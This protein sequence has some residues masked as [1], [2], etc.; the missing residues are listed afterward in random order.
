MLM[1][2]LYV[3][4]VFEHVPQTSALK[5]L[6]HSALLVLS[7]LFCFI[8]PKER[9]SNHSRSLS[10]SISLSLHLSLSPSPSFSPSPPGPLSSRRGSSGCFH[11]AKWLKEKGPLVIS[12]CGEGR[13]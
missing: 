5:P 7:R 8:F 11:G 4:D 10:L 9:V 6:S 1:A 13:A 2:L 12:R 3:L